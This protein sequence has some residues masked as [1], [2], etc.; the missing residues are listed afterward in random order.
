MVCIL[1]TNG[2][3]IKRAPDPP[4]VVSS[5]SSAGTDVVFEPEMA[6][7]LALKAQM[8][9]LFSIPS[10]S[11]ATFTE[12]GEAIPEED[13]EEI[14]MSEGE[15]Y[16]EEE[17]EEGTTARMS[18]QDLVDLYIPGIVGQDYRY[19]LLEGV[20]GSKRIQTAY[21]TAWGVKTSHMWDLLDRKEK[22]LIE[23]KVSTRNPEMLFAEL[24]MRETCDR[25]RYGMVVVKDIPDVS[26]TFL[27]CEVMKGE[28]LVTDF[29]LRRKTLLL[30][31]KSDLP[32]E[33]SENLCNFNVTFNTRS[34]E[35]LQPVLQAADGNL[36]PNVGV[37]TDEVLEAFEPDKL[38]GCLEDPRDR[39]APTIKWKGKLLPY[40]WVRVTTTETRKDS[41][42]VSELLEEID[43][44]EFCAV[45]WK[46]ENAD[47]LAKHAET[48][49]QAFV[50]ILKNDLNHVKVKSNRSGVYVI[51][52]RNFPN[53]KEVEIALAAVGV[54]KKPQRRT[55]KL[56][57]DMKQPKHT[58]LDPRKRKYD[59]WFTQLVK[60]E[61]QTS[62]WNA[63]DSVDFTEGP[64]THKWDA[65]AQ[66]ACRELYN[67][68]TR[69]RAGQTCYRAMNFYS[70]LGGPY[71]ID[72]TSGT[73]AHASVTLFPIYHVA[74][75]K[76][77]GDAEKETKRLVSGFA[78]RGPHHVKEST[79][80]INLLMFERVNPN[81]DVHECLEKGLL[82][83]NRW[84]VKQNAIR[85]A[86]PTYQSFLH[87]GLFVPMNYAGELIFSHPHF[88]DLQRREELWKTIFNDTLTRPQA[89]YR[90]RFSEITLQGILGTSQEEG[91]FSTLRMVYMLLLEHK[92]KERTYVMDLPGLADALNETLIDSAVAM[93][94]QS[95]LIDLLKIKG[96]REES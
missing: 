87:N 68:Y 81:C 63:S 48:L 8:T 32:T 72:I 17:E 15:D 69:S 45:N 56:A 27:E 36:P 7:S 86:D 73:G 84:F 4:A 39:V 12:E 93:Y 1:L 53:K 20:T 94:W 70:R 29:L 85:R 19:V 28:D 57:D 65:L 91:H 37:C 76:L 9:T 92:N 22:K 31:Y 6:S 3:K 95:C 49:I 42:I 62:S 78:I 5:S 88:G 30:A 64:R 14:E 2:E 59:G 67:S 75:R 18:E 41:D 60:D 43:F 83:K 50:H 23:V 21:T 90:E 35:W 25:A 77:P 71:A 16:Q 51:K 38:L 10:G 61:A 47:Q 74:H 66:N 80:K 24:T 40:S 89:F 82:L 46:K 79:D 33:D 55:E 54:G 11:S 44:D 58:E 52:D 13:P 34:C 96:S 26:F